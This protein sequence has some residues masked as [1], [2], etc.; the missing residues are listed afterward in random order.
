MSPAGK[1][2][3]VLFSSFLLKYRHSFR[4]FDMEIVISTY[5]WWFFVTFL[6]LSFFSFR[7]GC[8]AFCRSRKDNWLFVILKVL[9]YV[10]QLTFL[11]YIIFFIYKAPFWICHHNIL[12]SKIFT[13]MFLV[14]TLFTG[15]SNICFSVKKLLNKCQFQYQTFLKA[16]C[17]NCL[18]KW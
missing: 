10:P 2:R 13:V 5:V 7:I 4:S 14:F 12:C 17:M 11:N 1:K 15:R 6:W 18:K 8:G 16:P 9:K 3:P